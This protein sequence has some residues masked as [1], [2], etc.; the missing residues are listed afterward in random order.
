MP[1]DASGRL[2]LS[3][4]ALSVALGPTGH[5][6][7]TSPTDVTTFLYWGYPLSEPEALAGG[8]LFVLTPGEWQAMEATLGVTQDAT[9]AIVAFAVRSC[10]NL[11]T[12]VNDSGVQ[13]A[14]DR[15]P[16]LRP[17]YGLPPSASADATDLSGI[18]YFF[19][20]RANAAVSLTATPQGLGKPSS[21]STVFT[22]PGAITVV[23]MYPTP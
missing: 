11:L 15:T 18:G 9:L 14:L 2:R 8:G 20:V 17:Y 3:V 16:A 6:R 22:Q 10:S 21:H 4:P 1:T 23:W 7:V 12:A 5:L 19:N 13:V